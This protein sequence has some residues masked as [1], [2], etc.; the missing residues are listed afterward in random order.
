M[1]KRLL[2]G[3][4]RYTQNAKTDCAFEKMI[5]QSLDDVCA[6]P[7]IDHEQRYTITVNSIKTNLFVAY[8]YF[9]ETSDEQLSALQQVFAD[10]GKQGHL[11]ATYTLAKEVYR[12]DGR[13]GQHKMIKLM[14]STQAFDQDA[15]RK[16]AAFSF[17]DRY[18][19]LQVQECGSV[20]RPSNFEQYLSPT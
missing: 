10:K 5:G 9:N 1:I 19:V 14:L 3:S 17:D 6:R 16:V 18:D 20:A 2:T 11:H 13:P 7:L 8:G 12:F 15:W 4:Q